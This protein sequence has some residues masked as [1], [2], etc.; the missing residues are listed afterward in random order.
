VRDAIAR[1]LP[2]IEQTGAI[3]W[4]FGDLPRVVERGAVRGFPALVDEGATVGVRMCASP[5]EQRATMWAGTRR[6]LQLTAAPTPRSI[7]RRLS[8]AAK[9]ALARTNAVEVLDACIAAAIDDLLGAS[10]GPAWDAAA[11]EELRATVAH[12]AGQLATRVAQQSAGILG[13]VA[14]ISDRLATLAA[15]LLRESVADIRGQLDE[16]V[17]VTFPRSP[18]V[19][20]LDDVERY[21]RGIERRL[22]RLP[23]NPARDRELMARVHAIEDEHDRVVRRLPSAVQRAEARRIRWMIQELRV[24]LFAQTIGSAYPISEKRIRRA[25]EEIA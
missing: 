7:E 23:E 20:R 6:L 22:D 5:T 12:D 21:L 13:A 11:F 2:A 10:G 14:R 19:D 18:G 9:L 3:A 25:L 15:P 1:S 8:N 4:T 24:S 16:L 17:P